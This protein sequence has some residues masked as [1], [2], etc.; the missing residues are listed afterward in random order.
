MTFVRHPANPI[1]TREDIPDIPP[2]IHDPSSVFNPGAVFHDGKFRLLLRV[3][4]RGRETFLVPAVSDDGVSFTVA[5]R[6]A[7]IEGLDRIDATIYHVYDPRLTVIEGR[8]YGVFA[9]DTEDGCRLVTAGTDDFERFR[10]IGGVGEEDVRNGVLFPERVGGRYL[11]LD[12]PNRPDVPGQPGS[13]DEIRLSESDAL[14]TWSAAGP[15]MRGRWHYFDELIGA[16]PPPIRT[17]DGWLLVYHGI[18]THFAASNIYQA[19]V[20]L[21]DADDPT[22]VIARGRLNVLEPREAYELTGQVPNVV[23]PTGLIATDVDDAGI[24][25]RESPL[26]LYYGAADTVVALATSTVGAVLD[27]VSQ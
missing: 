7:V 5:D 25:T 17:A 18:A 15:V 22:T 11:R 27:G 23:F 2:A 10:M 4:T 14:A 8:G 13:G 6:L 1:V 21:L 3:Q 12:R 26:F 20:A 19:G 16:G 9:V 24:A